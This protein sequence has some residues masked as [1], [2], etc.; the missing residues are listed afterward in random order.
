MDLALTIIKEYPGLSASEVAREA[1]D[2]SSDLSDAKNAEQSFATTLNK[3]VQTGHEKRIRRER[4]G[5]L[6]RYFPASM[7][8]DSDSNG[9][10]FA[11]I[12]LPKDRLKDIDNLVAVDKFNNRSDAV[13]WLVIEGIKTNRAYLDKVADTRQQ[14]DKLRR[15][16]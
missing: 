6:Y 14:I 10:I 5:G 1:L 2:Y 11:Q 4:V 16:V 13:K 7:P 15:E 3:Q 8:A 9:E 12:S